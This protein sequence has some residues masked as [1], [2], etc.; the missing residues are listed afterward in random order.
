MVQNMTAVTS[1]IPVE[2]RMFYISHTSTIQFDADLFN[3]SVLHVGICLPQS[4][5]KVDAVMMGTNI[6]EKKYQD[7]LLFGDV[8]FLGTKTLLMRDNFFEEPFVVS[9]M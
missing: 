4:C 3:K 5:N 9:L 7:A 1:K 8:K 2:Y 6:F